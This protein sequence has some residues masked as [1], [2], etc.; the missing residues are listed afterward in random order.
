VKGAAVSQAAAR[1]WFV[2]H[3]KRSPG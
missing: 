3:L 2:E 1:D